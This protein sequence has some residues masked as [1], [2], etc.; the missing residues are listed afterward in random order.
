MPDQK[1]IAID[2]TQAAV[3]HDGLG[4][5]VLF[6]EDLLKLKSAAPYRGAIT[7]QIA[8]YRNLQ[9]HLAQAFPTLIP[10]STDAQPT[11]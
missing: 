5:A 4:K 10:S 6:V 2:G 8:A 1:V 3:I 11:E 9:A 7:M